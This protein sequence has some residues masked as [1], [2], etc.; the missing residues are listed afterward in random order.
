LRQLRDNFH[1]AK[2]FDSE[3]APLQSWM[4]AKKSPEPI[5]FDAGLLLDI[6]FT[7][8]ITLHKCS[9]TFAEIDESEMISHKSLA[10]KKI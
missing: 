4:V 7:S 8:K 1:T 2:H 9:T 3:L 6:I 10:C 5:T